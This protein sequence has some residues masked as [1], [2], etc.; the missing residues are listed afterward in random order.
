M[1]TRG[2]L[3]TIFKLS[4]PIMV[5]MV[6]VNLLTLID[7][8]MVGTLGNASLAAV[9][10]G[11]FMMN[12]A[13]A[14]FQGLAGGVQ[15]I[16]AR[17]F[18]EN[19]EDGTLPPLFGGIYYS[20]LVGIPATLFFLL[21]APFF[22]SILIEDV[23]VQ[24][25]GI[26]YFQIL[27]LSLVIQSF[28]FSFRGYFN[29]IARPSVYMNSLIIML[30]VDV[31]LNYMFIFGNFGAPRM[32]TAG[33]GVGTV[34]AVVV[35]TLWYIIIIR[36]APIT[37]DCFRRPQPAL[38]KNLLSLAIPNGMAQVSFGA[39]YT[40]FLWFVGMVGTAELA[41][42]NV[43]LRLLTLGYLPAVGMA[44]ASAALVGRSLGAGSPNDAARWCWEITAI[45]FL[46]MTL[47]GL[48][49]LI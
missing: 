37:R 6:A 29:G 47:L 32:G 17:R 8:A 40:L 5:G 3:N 1:I 33:A 15:A 48:P 2:R 18:G 20:L 12:L 22:F 43:L 38:R 23:A 4:A 9:G 34:G 45:S 13:T 7:T 11:S 21:T 27:V 35:A 42:A 16:T 19:K 36:K 10:L 41:A 30:V 25:E 28:C 14:F 24:K 26:P 46:S 31:I 49:A 44:R 39:C